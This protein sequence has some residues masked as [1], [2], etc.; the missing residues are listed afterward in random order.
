MTWMIWGSPLFQEPHI[1]IWL[2]IRFYWT[3]VSRCFQGVFNTR[4]KGFL[5]ILG[6][7]DGLLQNIWLLVCWCQLTCLRELE[8]PSSHGC[9]TFPFRKLICWPCN[10]PLC[11]FQVVFMSMFTWFHLEWRTNK[12][13][14]AKQT[15]GWNLKPSTY[16]VWLPPSDKFQKAHTKQCVNL[17]KHG[18]WEVSETS[19]GSEL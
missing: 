19:V 17:E 16:L 5:Y 13:L 8:P 9:P 15:G 3:M 14:W 2:Y 6:I 7:L 1:C 11:W 18:V 4:G 12:S 10:F